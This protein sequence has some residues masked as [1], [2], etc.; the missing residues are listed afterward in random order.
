MD[1]LERHVAA[2][3]LLRRWALDGVAVGFVAIGER[4]GSLSPAG[5]SSGETGAQA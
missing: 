2:R 1:S 4:A 3:L 5:S